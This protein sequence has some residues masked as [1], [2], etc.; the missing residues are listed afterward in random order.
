MVLQQ[1]DFVFKF[2]V[3]EAFAILVDLV[4]VRDVSQTQRSAYA[5]GEVDNVVVDK[6]TLDGQASLSTRAWWNVESPVYGAV[7]PSIDISHTYKEDNV[8]QDKIEVFLLVEISLDGERVIGVE[9]YGE[10]EEHEPDVAHIA[11]VYLVVSPLNK[12]RDKDDSQP[13]ADVGQYGAGK[14]FVIG[15]QLAHGSNYWLMVGS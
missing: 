5:Q 15:T 2:L 4:D 12:E 1:V 13:H 14:E 11:D 8:E 10:A 9:C 6:Q 3:L 7:D